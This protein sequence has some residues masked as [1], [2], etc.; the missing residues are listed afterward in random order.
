MLSPSAGPLN[1]DQTRR[2]GTSLDLLYNS[3]ECQQVPL[4][5]AAAPAAA[6]RGGGGRGN[7]AQKQR[8][9]LVCQE[10]FSDTHISP[11]MDDD[12]GAAL[13]IA[14]QGDLNTHV[15]RSVTFLS[16]AAAAPLSVKRRSTSISKL[17]KHSEINKVEAKLNSI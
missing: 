7:A 2:A 8:P 12:G 10:L 13:C 14:G 9:P 11:L 16:E 17:M 5:A 1:T 4:A 3:C 6:P 15:R